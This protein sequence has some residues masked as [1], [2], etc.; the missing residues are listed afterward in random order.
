MEAGFRGMIVA[1][2]CEGVPWSG[3]LTQMTADSSRFLISL[4][5]PAIHPLPYV[6]DS[7]CSEH[8]NRISLSSDHK[9]CLSEG[10]LRRVLLLCP[11]RVWPGADVRP[12]APELQ[13]DWRPT[14]DFPTGMQVS[15]RMALTPMSAPGSAFPSAR[16]LLTLASVQRT[17]LWSGVQNVSFRWFRLGI[18]RTPPSVCC[19]PVFKPSAKCQGAAGADTSG[20]KAPGTEYTLPNSDIRH[21]QTSSGQEKSCERRG[22]AGPAL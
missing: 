16:Q 13:S 9:P 1:V 19:K 5:A 2:R 11:A 10:R 17:S 15:V 18:T 14:G 3:C 6:N 12:A 7:V 21:K 22:A 8:D 20:N 4:S